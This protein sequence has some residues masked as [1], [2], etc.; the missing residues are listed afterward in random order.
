MGLYIS[1]APCY[2]AEHGMIPRWPMLWQRRARR[3]HHYREGVA[4]GS[5]QHVSRGAV[6]SV[7][8]G[9]TRRLLRAR[10]LMKPW[11]LQDGVGT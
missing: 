3:S 7:I 1:T 6:A 8:P 4:C 2:D 5:L 11:R 9:G 10:I